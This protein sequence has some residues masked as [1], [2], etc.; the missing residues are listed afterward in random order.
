[1]QNSPTQKTSNMGGTKP[2]DN[3]LTQ[4]IIKKKVAKSQNYTGRVSPL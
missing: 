2:E 1:V 3:S 4:L